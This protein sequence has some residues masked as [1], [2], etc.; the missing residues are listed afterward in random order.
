MLFPL[1][2]V[3]SHESGSEANLTDKQSVLRNARSAMQDAPY[4]RLLIL[5]DGFAG[6]TGRHGVG[7]ETRSGSAAGI[8]ASCQLHN[9]SFL[10]D[11]HQI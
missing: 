9:A 8:R 6:L 5:G 11:W 2:A 1:R 10:R 7:E 4:K 3:S